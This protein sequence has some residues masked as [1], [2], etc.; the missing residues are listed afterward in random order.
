M[1]QESQ[2]F[3]LSLL[4]EQKNNELLIKD[5][6]SRLSY[7]VKIFIPNL[8]TKEEKIETLNEIFKGDDDL[9]RVN[10]SGVLIKYV[11]PYLYPLSSMTKEQK[12]YL[13]WHTKYR[14][15]DGEIVVKRDEDNEYL[16]TNIYDYLSLIEWFH[17]NHIDYMGLIE[18]ELAI[19]C[20]NLNLY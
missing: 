5:L 9:Y 1:K 16:H 3:L 12:L 8:W 20:T 15:D 11:K 14:L 6:S 10:S 7:G 2:E 18:K 4:K 13:E 19:D 17:K